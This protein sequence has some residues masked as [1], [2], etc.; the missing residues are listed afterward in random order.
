MDDKKIMLDYYDGFEES[1]GCP[2]GCF[3]NEETETEYFN[4]LQQCLE[5]GKSLSDEQ[6]RKYFPHEIH[7]PAD[8][9]I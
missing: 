5:T 4:A 3:P 2:L 8:K 1:A 7:C 6:R 9:D